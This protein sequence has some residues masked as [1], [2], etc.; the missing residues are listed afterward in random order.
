M[1]ELKVVFLGTSSGVPTKTRNHT[2][3]L[4]VYNGCYLL[5]DC[6]EGTQRQMARLEISPLRIDKIFI[7]HLHADHVLGLAG[8]LQ[9]LAMK[10]YEKELEIYG[11]VG[12]KNYMKSIEENFHIL[13][14]LKL[15][16]TE[17]DKDAVFDFERFSIEAIELCHI[18]KAFGYV[19]KEKD[20]VK[21]KPKYVRLLGGPSP[22]FKLLKQGIA[23]EHK[24]RKIKPE[25]ATTVEKGRK[26]SFVFDT[27]KCD[28]AFKIAKEADLLII[29]A[30]YMKEMQ[31]LAEEYYHLTTTDVAEVIRKCKPKITA[32]THMSE[33]YAGKESK[34]LAE[35]KQGIKKTKA[36]VFVAEDLQAITL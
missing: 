9:T 23:I 15:K 2:S 20:K 27:K 32:L 13:K 24:G 34:L 30:T 10:N 12:L 28:G 33:R 14:F 25:E 5:F 3:I 7:T 11:P 17:I 35:V 31:K 21:I 26:V 19:F 8:L 4:L 16:I 6:G 1:K 29:E 36:K 18:T 22:L